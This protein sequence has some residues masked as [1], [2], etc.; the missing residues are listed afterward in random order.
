MRCRTAHLRLAA[1]MVLALAVALFIGRGV[2][3]TLLMMVFIV[4]LVGMY[5]L[6][7]YARAEL[8]NRRIAEHRRR[9]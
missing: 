4:G 6:R 2:I 3:D 9:H 1:V 5:G 8:V 7:R